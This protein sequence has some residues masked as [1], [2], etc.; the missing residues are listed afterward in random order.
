MAEIIT[1]TIED[2]QLVTVVGTP[3]VITIVD[4]A[5]DHGQMAGLG[6]DD[7][8]QYVK[9]VVSELRPDDPRPGT[10]WIPSS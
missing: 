6:D 10:M 4:D 2:S 1:F 5:P 9:Y 3:E 8:P 7:H